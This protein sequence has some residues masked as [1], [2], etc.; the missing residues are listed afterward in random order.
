MRSGYMVRLIRDGVTDWFLLHAPKR[1]H[2]G[3]TVTAT[4]TCEHICS[5]LAKKNIY[6][7]FDDTNGIGTAR[8][9]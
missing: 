8:Y 4:V 5:L 7:I 6:M 9:L 1:S 2:K 3:Q